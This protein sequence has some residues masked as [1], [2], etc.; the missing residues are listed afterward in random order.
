MMNKL[1]QINLYNNADG[2]KGFGPLGLVGKTGTDAPNVFANF[3][4]G[5]VG[6]ITV[7]GIIWFIFVITT[8]AVSIIT[9]GGDKQGLEGA[10][11]RITNG[12]IGLVV[13]ITALLILNLVG[14]FL[15]IPTLL[16]FTEMF[17]KITNP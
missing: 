8:G 4:S 13:S 3:I 17:G 2:F 10:K 14:T 5:A 7:I 1:A 11:K 6:I 9:S 15:G 12:I 16:N